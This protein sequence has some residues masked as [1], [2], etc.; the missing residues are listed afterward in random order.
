[1]RLLI[2]GATGPVGILLAREALTSLENCSLVL[3]IRS[4]DKVPEDIKSNPAVTI[5]E[6]Q[7]TNL[8]SLSGAME[9]VDAVLSALGPSVRKGPFHPSGCPLAAAIE[10]V[11]QIMHKKGI[12]R[13]IVLGTASIT[14]P[15][16]KP[17]IKFKALVTAV[18]LGAHNAYKDVV[19]IGENI[20]KESDLDWTIV[21]VPLLTDKEK[22]DVV[23]GFIGDGKVGTTLARVGF[24]VFVIRGLLKMNNSAWIRKAPVICTP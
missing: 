7:L 3:Y 11:I 23:S 4:P 24:G 2:L 13:L 1:M 18:S 17:D 14:A 22:R 21:R 5:I 12:K 16:D 8:E 15:E 20:K 10:N 19:A 9:G 6:G